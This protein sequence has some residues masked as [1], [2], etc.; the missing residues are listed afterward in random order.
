MHTR[1]TNRITRGVAA[2]LLAAAL[3]AQPALIAAQQGDWPS[4]PPFYAIR[5]AR[6]V[7]VSGP[8]I[9]DG[10]VVVANGVITAVGANAT[11]PAEAWVIDGKGLTVYP[12]LIDA[13]TNIGLP[14][15]QAPAAGAATFEQAAQQAARQPIAMGPEDRPGT[16]SWENAADQ[17]KTD[18]KRIENWRKQ[19]FTT[20]V[21]APDRGMICGTA[22][23]INL[24]GNRPGDVVVRT[25]AALRL[26]LRPSGG[27]WSFPGS[28]MGVLAYL[29]QV[30]AD[31]DQS[32]NAWAMYSANPKGLERPAYDRSLGPLTDAVNNKWPVLIPATW[33]KEILRGMQLGEDLKVQTVIYGAHQGYAV[34]DAV[35]AK[36]VPVLVSLK[37]PEK[38]QG[39]DPDAE[40]PLRTLRLRERAPSTPAALH[41]AG[42]KF[43]F[44]SDGIAN[45]KD[46]FKNVKKAIDA[47]LPAD[48]AL[49]ALTLSPAEIFNVA[50]R[51][52][53]IE[54]GKAANLVVTDGDLFEEKTKIKMVFVDGRKYEIREP[55]R[56]E[57]KPSI[58]LTGTW[59]LSV[60]MPQGAQEST[61]ELKMADDGTLSGS[62]TGQRG[63]ASLSSGWVSGNNFSF[64][65]SIS[66]G[67]RTVEVVYTGT[68]EGNKM[69][70]SASM[71]PMSIQFTGTRPEGN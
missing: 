66:M 30:F 43:G 18:D 12:G 17:I 56:P 11:I 22:A 57:E 33:S 16:T 28:L 4:P 23:V 54:A 41:K 46:L 67:P 68:V 36:K 61:A 53:S 8:V 63:T 40:E 5:G 3:V 10:T 55:G 7:P 29:K 65:V 45:S 62:V 15:P 26:T 71:G 59:K 2:L 21:T 25:P 34:A 60:N 64:T 58:N 9:E 52:G 51:V 47:G 49:R 14:Q 44:Y 24:A 19:G 69:T 32:S 31:A 38:E 70:G 35:A 42:V 27:F 50:D 39:G 48:A 37:W 20:V 1:S 6:I 13:L